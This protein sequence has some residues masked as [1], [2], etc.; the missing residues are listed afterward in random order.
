[1]KPILTIV[2]AIAFLV[3]AQSTRSNPILLSPCNELQIAGGNNW[4]LEMYASDP[5]GVLDGWHIRTNSGTAIF[6]NGIH[7]GGGSGYLLITQDSLLSPLTIDPLGDSLVIQ[8]SGGSFM[9][10]LTF[11]DCPSSMICSPG[12]GQS[13]CW[14][15]FDI[16]YLDNSPT[17]GSHNDSTNAM[18]T[19]A[20]VVADSLGRPVRQVLVT[21]SGWPNLS[22]YSDSCGR[23]ELQGLASRCEVTFVHANCIARSATVQARPESTI[24]VNMVL[25]CLAAVNDQPE[26]LHDFRLLQNYPNPFNP[27]TSFSFTIPRRSFVSLKIYDIFGREVATVVNEARNAGAYEAQWDAS[28]MASGVYFYRLTA[29]GWL[30]TRKMVL[31]R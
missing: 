1:M 17:L 8:S 24:T 12:P 10:H 29:N 6:K 27:M 18:G 21:N 22:A 15:G 11:G 13:I 9:G 26:P 19:I 14:R 3:I 23:F 7:L 16:Y 2:A 31:L 25:D 20:G 28:N 4:I 5:I 30:Q